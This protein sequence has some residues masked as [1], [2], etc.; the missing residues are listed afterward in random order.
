MDE[1]WRASASDLATLLTRKEISARETVDTFLSR[2]SADAN[3]AF[4]TVT[5]DSARAQAEAVDQARAQGTA[6]PAFAGVPIAIKDLTD[7]AG[8]H[9][10]FGSRLMADYIAPR[11]AYLV[12]LLNQAGFISLGKTNTPEFG[13]SSFTDNQV[14]GPARAPANPELNAG[15]SSGGAAVAVANHLVPLA[16]GSDG[17]G[18]IRIPAS[19]CGVFGFKPSRGRVSPGPVGSDLTGLT[20]DGPIT[21]TVRDAAVFMDVVAKPMPGDFRPLPVES[22]SFVDALHTEPPGLRI[23]CFSNPY[24]DGID[25]HP[26]AVAAWQ[27]AKERLARLGHELVDIPNPFPAELE[28]QFNIVWST[29][30]ASLE[31]SDGDV[32]LLT[33]TTRYWR[34]RGLAT[35]GTEVMRAMRFLQSTTREVLISLQDFDAFL[36]PT[37]ALPPQ[38][39]EWFT[40]T[41]S[42]EATH[43]RELQ[44]TPFTAVYNISGQPAASLP[45]WT[46]SAGLPIGVMLATHPNHDALLLQLSHQ[47]LGA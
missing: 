21:R 29:S 35:S 34:D 47:L 46:N 20:I 38:K 10:S 31:L 22:Q 2:I 25:T 42:P 26:D 4:I 24:L 1:I 14:I 33:R 40:E 23:A 16:H 43:A 12:D 13:L 6:L 9:T 41:A 27:H 30:M 5:A 19:C 37:L 7:I 17:G 44:F 45:L 8:V 36:T 39:H 11:N 28:P 15:G 32:D 3:G 18:S